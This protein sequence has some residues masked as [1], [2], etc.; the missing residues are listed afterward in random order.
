MGEKTR[1][2]TLTIRITR[3]GWIISVRVEYVTV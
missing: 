3:T 2:I 1:T